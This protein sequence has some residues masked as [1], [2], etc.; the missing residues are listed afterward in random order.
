MIF[1]IGTRFEQ[2]GQQNDSDFE[3][4]EAQGTITKR[5]SQKKQPDEHWHIV[6]VPKTAA[7][8]DS[9][10]HHLHANRVIGFHCCNVAITR[11]GPA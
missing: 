8:N 6:A 7:S 9:I 1:T 4:S 11:S 5:K 3:D 2:Q 10:I